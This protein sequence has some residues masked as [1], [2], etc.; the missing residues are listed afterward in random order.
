[1]PRLVV[2]DPSQVQRIYRES[3]A[4]W[5]AGL[6]RLDYLELWNEI[7][8]TRWGRENARFYVWLDDDGEILSSLKVYRPKLQWMGQSRLAIV[9]G[10]IFTP[11]ARR[12]QGHAAA[13]VRAAL[14]VGR[15]A[16]AA[17]A[18]LFSDIG[19][20]YYEALG[21]REIPAEEQWGPLPHHAAE[22]RT[23][24]HLRDMQPEDLPAMIEMHSAFC[25][26]RPFAFLRDAD[27]WDFV[28]T[29]AFSFFRRLG[30]AHVRQRWRVAVC[31]GQVVGYLITVEGRG[32]WSIREVGARDG[33]FGGMARVLRLGAADAT[34]SGLRRFYAWLPGEVLENLDDWE[35]RSSSRRGAV[36]MVLPLTGSPEIPELLV[37]GAAYMPYQDQF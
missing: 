21:F 20:R 32:E 9:L 14:G 3:Y 23:G 4:L 16:G 29:R 1:M 13:A 28:R 15:D 19:T 6:T 31:G 27:H 7:R 25:A 12:R 36:P 10:A 35:V 37:P 34:R 30:S 33:E 17:A 8:S 5:G 11:R 2:A 26:A 24:W 18:I 22:T